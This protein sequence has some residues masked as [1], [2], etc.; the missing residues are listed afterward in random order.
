MKGKDYHSTG[1]DGTG[2]NRYNSTLS[3]TLELDGG[4]WLIPRSDPLSPRKR[5]GT[6]F[7][8]GLVGPTAGLKVYEKPTPTW[9]RFLD[10]PACS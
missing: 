2:R 7:V 4:V 5:F 10:P 1:H 8:G 9:F 6:H 3:L